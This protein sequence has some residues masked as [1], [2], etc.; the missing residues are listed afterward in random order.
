MVNN[1]LPS[2]ATNPH[3]YTFGNFGDYGSSGNATDWEVY[4]LINN[5]A[6][7]T[8]VSTTEFVINSIN[9]TGQL[10]AGEKVVVTNNGVFSIPATT[11]TVT[12]TGAPYP[13]NSTYVEVNGSIV[14]ATIDGV[15]KLVYEYL[16]IGWDSDPDIIQNINDYAFAIDHI[17]APLGTDGTYGI[18]ALKEALTQGRNIIYKNL[19]KT[20][21]ME[22]TYER[23]AT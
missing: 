22:T 23:F 11:I 14:Q 18:I 21:G 10:S 20:E 13:P 2:K 19:Q 12:V 8:Q 17:H 6:V 3:V 5:T 15:W 4:D 9:I 16:G 7:F 1:L